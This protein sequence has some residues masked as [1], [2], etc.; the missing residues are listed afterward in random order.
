MGMGRIGI[1]GK[2]T[3]LLAALLLLSTVSPSAE[4]ADPVAATAPEAEQTLTFDLVVNGAVAGRRD[5]TITYLTPS[6]PGGSE[7]RLI[8]TW[9]ELDARAGAWT[10]QLQNRSSGHISAT[11]SGFTS[12]LSFNGKVSEVQG[13]T[14]P[15]GRWQMHGVFNRRLQTWELRRT[16]VDLSSLDLLDPVR[17][18]VMAELGRAR[19]LSAETGQIMTGPIEDL[20][21]Q[22]L[23]IRG[24]EVV[25]HRYAWTPP[26]GRFELA[27]SEDGLLLDWSITASGQTIDARL[28]SLPPP[29]AYGTVEASTTAEMPAFREEEL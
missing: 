26:E 18:K 3:A 5:V 20:G 27:W 16:E 21:E 14:L 10:V 29:R 7:S 17:A 11:E 22:V 15:D 25:V 23:V 2:T 1:F 9:T 24:Q 12:S 28:R 8:K 19:I 6:Q 13:A 4:A